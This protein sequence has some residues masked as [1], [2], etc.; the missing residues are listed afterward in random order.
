MTQ[1][2][3][4]IA[5]FLKI[6]DI[7]A[8]EARNVLLIRRLGAV[9]FRLKNRGFKFNRTF[10]KDST[11]RTYIRYHLAEWPAPRPVVKPPQPA[12]LELRFVA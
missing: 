5:H 3:L 2:E 6:P 1:E 12:Q 7:T 8:D 10:H 9:I 4:L 11:G